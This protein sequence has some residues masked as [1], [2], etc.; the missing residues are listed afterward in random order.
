MRALA[1]YF[2]VVT[3]AIASLSDQTQ[4]TYS[5]VIETLK[6]QI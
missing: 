4:A 3:E 2:S 6:I 1:K 5:Y